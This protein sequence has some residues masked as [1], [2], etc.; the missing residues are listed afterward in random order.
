LKPFFGLWALEL[1]CRKWTPDVLESRDYSKLRASYT[2]TKKR[3]SLSCGL[4]RLGAIF[5][6]ASLMVDPI[7]RGGGPNGISVH[8][9]EESVRKDDSGSDSVLTQN[10]LATN[11]FFYDLRYYFFII[12]YRPY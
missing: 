6:P 11:Y 1:S 9:G 12:Q 8:S 5:Q 10:V 2:A 4:D 7:C 3:R